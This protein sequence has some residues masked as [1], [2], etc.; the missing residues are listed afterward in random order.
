LTTVCGSESLLV[1]VTVVPAGTVTVAGR[2][3]KFWMVTLTTP[4]MARVVGTVVTMVAW[5]VATVVVGGTVVITVVMTVV[6]GGAVVAEVAGVVTGAGVVGAVV[7]PARST[8]IMTTSS[9]AGTMI[10]CFD[11]EG[12]GVIP[13]SSSCEPLLR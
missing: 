9:I 5:V 2:K 7:H 8:V 6:A 12:E 3:A 10:P 11:G 4:G 1:Q 13:D